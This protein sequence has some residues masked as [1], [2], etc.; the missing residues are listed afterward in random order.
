[1]EI[2]MTIRPFPLSLAAAVLLSLVAQALA[3]SEEDPS[4]SARLRQQAAGQQAAGQAAAQS[5]I[6]LQV[7]VR[8][9]PGALRQLQ[10]VQAQQAAVVVRQGGQ[11]FD[12]ERAD[13]D[14]SDAT[15]RV[16]LLAPGGPLILQATITIDG[17]PFRAP[18][19][20]IV[21]ELLAAAD[22]DG[23]G[24]ATWAE[25]LVN[26][27]FS[28]GR[29]RALNAENL[30]R[31]IKQ[32]DSNADTLVDRGEARRF[33]AQSYGGPT[34]LVAPG[35]SAMPQTDLF[36]LL[37]TTA[38]G[39][40]SAEEIAAAPQRLKSRD[41][42][43]ND[44]VTAY[45][46]ASVPQQG[47]R[48]AG[49]YYAAPQ[50]LA[51]LL[52]PASKS[53][54]IFAALKQRYA[55]K[56]GL[57]AREAFHALPELFAQLDR[58][59]NGQLDI[60]ELPQLHE[61]PP[62]LAVEIN[63]G[64]AEGESVVCKSI[65]PPW[66]GA[67]KTTA[68]N[69][70]T[71][72]LSA[73][74]LELTA[75]SAVNRALANYEQ[76]AKRQL[77]QFDSDKNGYLELKELPPGVAQQFELWDSDTDGKV[78]E[79]EILQSYYRQTAPL[80]SQ[81]QLTAAHK[82]DP[83]F[84]ALDSSPDGSLSLREMRAAASAL[85]RLDRNGDGRIGLDEAPPTLRVAIGRGGSTSSAGGFVLRTQGAPVRPGQRGP[86]PDWFDSMDRNGD[87]DLSPREFL[88]SDE[89]FQKLDLDADG[90]IDRQEAQGTK[91]PKPFPIEAPPVDGRQ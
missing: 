73:I 62:H 80:L 65:A 68:R 46:L 78:F 61:L 54:A 50:A 8:E 49:G 71:L 66:A 10:V 57:I 17:Q 91:A 86:G 9:Q 38:D 77:A 79:K 14:P 19:E 53:E 12:N 22:K 29:F 84:E 13:V 11:G 64:S 5:A 89:Q 82:A 39:G 20:K 37:D 85:A 36:K 51:V 4:N 58:D 35:Y 47:G 2:A 26:P 3:Q 48:V 83:F 16:L 72:A 7:L 56:T 1:M 21:D 6:P 90:L 33:L 30:A 28:Y 43:D 60:E 88:G 52:G 15:E 41:A 55:G 81:V 45:E 87:G 25:A 42:N 40:L 34:F 63:L 59:Q 44:L 31:F 24:K 18:R 27:R 23:D 67:A 69:S 76:T 32:F 70:V 75:A 74:Q